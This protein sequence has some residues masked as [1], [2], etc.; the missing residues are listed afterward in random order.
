M[1][2]FKTLSFINAFIK[3]P[4]CGEYIHVVIIDDIVVTKRK[5]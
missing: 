2:N 3:C 4:L 1:A 5:K